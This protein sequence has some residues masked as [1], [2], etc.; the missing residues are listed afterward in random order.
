MTSTTQRATL[1][2]VDFGRQLVE[3]GDLDPIYIM[4]HGAKLPLTKL[5]Q[6]L[7]A[8]WCFYHAGTASYCVDVAAVDG[9]EASYW[10]AMRAAAASSKWPRGSERRHFRA[11]LAMKSVNW[12]ESEGVES[13]FYD[14]D[15]AAYEC[16]VLSVQDVMEHV[17][18]WV[19]FGPWIA[20]KVADMLERLGLVKVNFTD[21]D[22]F[23][24][25]APLEGAKLVV[26]HYAP[27]QFKLVT[28]EA[29]WAFS[30]LRRNLAGL[31]APP[32]YERELNGQE[33]ETIL[34]KWKSHLAG[35]YPIGKD[36]HEIREGLLRFARC[37][38]SQLL[39]RSLPPC[40]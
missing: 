10:Q 13:L 6:W 5:Q 35:H 39:L 8:Y 38:T 20:F 34:C 27:K 1:S 7:L 15:R 4:L 28:T 37:K 30:Y 31:K 33:F 21:A 2:V 29:A 14:F 23:L 25:K 11:D 26:E 22:A 12:L 24:F 40:V 32:R 19:G 9:R 17:E 16:R 36:I 3:T 18:L